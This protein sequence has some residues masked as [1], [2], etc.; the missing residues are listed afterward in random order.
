MTSLPESLGDLQN[1]EVLDLKD[2]KLVSLPH[3]LGLL[4]KVIKLNLDGN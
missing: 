1:L 4:S 2:N 3:R